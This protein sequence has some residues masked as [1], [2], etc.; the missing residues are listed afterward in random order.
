MQ[1]D[2]AV[3]E[4][5]RARI[6][7]GARFLGPANLLVMPSLDAANITYNALKILGDGV[8]VGPILMGMNHP[9]HVLTNAVTV[10][11]I[12]NMS[13]FAVAHEAEFEARHR[14]RI[15]EVEDEE[16]DYS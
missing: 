16:D 8:P 13:A 15:S 7:P 4:E 6:F 5:I 11:G 10:R 12:V 2:A 1:A 3:S 9:V 14:D